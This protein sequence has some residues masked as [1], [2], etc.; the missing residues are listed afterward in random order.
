MA[1]T[2]TVGRR[3]Q[4]LHKIKEARKLLLEVCVSFYVYAERAEDYICSSFDF[5][6]K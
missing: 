6:L 2:V 3:G 5:Y 4:Y 1:E